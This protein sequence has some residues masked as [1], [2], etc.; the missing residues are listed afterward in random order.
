MSSQTVEAPPPVRA[1]SIA[2]RRRTHAG[3]IRPILGLPG[4][5]WI[6]SAIALLAKV[7]Q[8]TAEALEADLD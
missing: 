8:R 6:L 2:R 5:P 4:A 7:M 3:A 1:P